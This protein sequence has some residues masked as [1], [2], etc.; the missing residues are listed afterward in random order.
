VYVR[1]CARAIAT[2]H[3]AK[4]HQHDIY[5]VGLGE[6]HSL[7]EVGR[8]FETL[9]PGTTFNLG[10]A[11]GADTTYVPQTDYDIRTCLDISRIRE[12]FGWVPEY[13]LEKG[14]AA[15]AA[16]IRDGSYI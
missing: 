7:G 9:F 14:L 11:R 3:L 15:T 4:N 16:F 6:Y 5:N 8:I 13:S 2:I 10:K 12:E 1:D